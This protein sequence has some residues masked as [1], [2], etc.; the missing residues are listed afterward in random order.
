MRQAALSRLLD[1]SKRRLDA[2]DVHG[3]PSEEYRRAAYLLY[4]I[5][6]DLHTALQEVEREF[7]DAYEAFKNIVQKQEAQKA[8]DYIGAI[9]S[10]VEGQDKKSARAIS[11]NYL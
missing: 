11:G 9:I 10:E 5:V 7:D 4:E 6:K 1:E 2:F 3:I 8:H